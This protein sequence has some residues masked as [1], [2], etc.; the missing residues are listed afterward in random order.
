MLLVLEVS[1]YHGSLNEMAAGIGTFSILCKVAYTRKPECVL[2]F[3]NSP[4][5][6]VADRIGYVTVEDLCESL[7]NHVGAEKKMKKISCNHCRKVNMGNHRMAVR[8]Q[9]KK[10]NQNEKEQASPFIGREF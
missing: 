8:K 9:N 4:P 10:E 5:P 3:Y 7:A 6:I 2:M 1:W